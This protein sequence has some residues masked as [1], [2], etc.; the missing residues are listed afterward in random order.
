MKLNFATIS[1]KVSSL[2][3]KGGA[4]V[5]AAGMLLSLATPIV[6]K[7][8][9][10]TAPGARV[11]FT[12]DDGLAS[13]LS[14]AAPTLAKYGFS[15]TDY[16]ITQ[17]IGMTTAPNTCHANTAATYM[18]WAKVA[19][20]NAAPYNWEIASHTQTHPYLASSDATDGQPNV[21]TPAEVASQLANAKIDFTGHGITA[22]DF[23]SPYGDWTPPVLAQIA[24]NYASHRGFADSID[25]TGPA[26][27]ADGVI[28]HGNTFPYND[29][30]I[31]DLQVQ[32]G[33]SVATVE[34]Y[35]DQS[36]ANGQWLVMTFHDIKVNASTNADDY[37]YKTADLDAIAA[38]V[39]SKNVPVVTVGQGLVTNVGNLLPNSSFDTAISSNIA[40]P[41][42]WSTDDATNIKQDTLSHGNYPSAANSVALNGTTKNI[43]LFSPQVPVSL[44]PYVIKN[45]LNVQ[46]MTVAAGHE[47]AFYV[48]EYDA[49]G[50]F[51]Q[52]QYKRSEV[53]NA[54]NAAGMWVEDLNFE[55]TPTNATVAKARLQVVVTANSG[56]Q[57]F[58]DNVQWFAEDGSTTGGAGAVVGKV[59]DLNASGHV[60]ITDLSILL[61]NWGKSGAIG[62]LDTNPL[63][64]IN[65]LSILLSNWG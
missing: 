6:P 60:D 43:E 48:D 58:L 44:K 65:D 24:K 10:V 52:T 14:D 18:D 63:I 25:Q 9:A 17:C 51:L 28:D 40:D 30:L 34:K 19:A 55:Y 38:Y 45:Y 49:N 22:T 57:A 56:A 11:S 39:K 7:A 36:I 26:L 64:N 2:F 46:K 32:A 31:Y 12:F 61:S 27:V 16:V 3:K 33:V 37:E 42:V 50:T 15:G 41:T 1:K 21:L 35:I 13:A 54:G 62:N 23:A 4:T 29:Y 47:I 53:G 59:G 5:L 8:H 20:L